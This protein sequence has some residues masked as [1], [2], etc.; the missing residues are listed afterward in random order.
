MGLDVVLVLGFWRRHK[1]ST[2]T[3]TIFNGISHAAW[4]LH[5]RRKQ[6]PPLDKGG[7]QGGFERRNEPTPA[8]RDR[9]K[10]SQDFTS[11]PPLRG[12][13]FSVQSVFPS[14]QPLKASRPLSFTTAVI[15]PSFP[16]WGILKGDLL[17]VGIVNDEG[18][19]LEFQ[20]CEKHLFYSP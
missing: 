8:L 1:P 20:P 16:V 14:P 10:S 17:A 7:L 13:G 11:A 6:R 19:R 3:N 15:L 12:R 5:V 18:L 4:R 2:R 9:V